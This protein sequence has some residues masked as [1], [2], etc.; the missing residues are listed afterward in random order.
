MTYRQDCSPHKTF[1]D[2][3]APCGEALDAT[4]ATRTCRCG[5]T[6]NSVQRLLAVL[7][8]FDPSPPTLTVDSPHNGDTVPLGFDI[9]SE[10]SDN[11]GIGHVEVEIDGTMAPNTASQPP[12]TIR[13][14]LG[15]SLGMHNLE[16]RAYDNA[17][18]YTPELLTV[19]VQAACAADADCGKDFTCMNSACYADLGGSCISNDDC[20]SQLCIDSE[21]MDGTQVC[22]QDCSGSC[23]SGFS[24][25]APFGGGSD[26]C[27][28]G[29]GGG[30]AASPGA[31]RAPGVIGALFMIGLLGIGLLRRRRA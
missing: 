20:V 30:C 2:F 16:V 12:Y 31:Q 21:K 28:S 15:L 25:K 17:G 3:D 29:G 13:T 6:Q 22:S 26:K 11:S 7:G 18:N 27:F 1:Q 5:L 23:P 8:P 14:P 19:N 24:C 4:G 9:V 10:A